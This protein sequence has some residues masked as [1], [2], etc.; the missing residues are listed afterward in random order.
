MKTE[1]FEIADHLFKFAP[2]RR[3]PRSTVAEL[4]AQ[5]E[6]SYFRADTQILERGQVNHNLYFIRKGAVEVFR[7]SG[8][9]FDRLGEGICFGQFS[10]L[11]GKK[12]RY[13]VRSLEDTLVYMIPDEQFQYLYNTYDAFAD[14]MEEDT[15]S[16]LQSAVNR[17][18][19]SI[20]NR[21]LNTPV[22][23]LV[24]RK[25]VT[26]VPETT[27]REAARI[28][29]RK[30]ISSLVILQKRPSKTKDAQAIA[31]ILTDRDIRS[32]AVAAGLDFSVP[33]A[34]IMSKGVYT[35]QTGI[36]AS[37]AML[38]MI[39]Y[40]VHH[41]PVLEKET[42][43]GVVSAT[44]IIQYES[45][46]SVYLSTNIFRQKNL[47]GLKAVAGRLNTSFIHQVHQGGSFRII[48]A[49]LSGIGLN[50]AQRL[51]ELGE[52]RL[53]PP[54]VPYCF[55]VMGSMARNEQLIVTD[56]DNAMI[57]DNTFD[58]EVHD[59]YF[60][61]LARFVTNGLEQCGYPLC[62]GGIMATNP[63]WRVSL[64]QWE[65]YFLEWI[66][67]PNP[68]FLLN[69]SIFFDLEG[70]YGQIDLARDLNRV[71][72][73]NTRTHQS[74]LACMAHI[75]VQRKP[76]LGFFR[77]F[78]LEPDGENVNTFNIKRRGTAPITDL[79]RVHA[80]A[81]GSDKRNTIKRLK[82]IK[83]TAL[84]PE[85]SAEDLEDALEF[86]C[87]VRIR[88]QARQIEAGNQPSNSVKPEDLSG[89]ERRH[90]KD[91]F[92]IINSQQAFLRHRYAAAGKQGVK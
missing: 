12:V 87:M 17:K 45:H 23:K 24:H 81:C 77:Q 65:T 19:L 26:A 3:L 66:E 75:A 38:G 36:S 76:P 82:D 25:L 88:N 73:E 1:L 58:P 90:L 5:I 50:F 20:D 28:M 89:F 2:F 11:R 33:V 78:A 7:S 85:G 41:M 44:D 27:I 86:I 40:N 69:S 13:P 34:R 68:E 60:E 31:G 74:F 92:K 55:V 32:R 8:E 15:G 84:L 51:L 54:P 83:K 80:L 62:K 70:V 22:E 10:L 37:E 64:K 39:R 43:V 21:L 6:V 48:G 47:D 49:T 9:L 61:S 91:A 56:Q 29:C 71:I 53:G 63:K 35:C 42:P 30:R 72:H 18:R 79:V 67:H 4:A 46:G 52:K 14:Y 57:L 16:R 59:A